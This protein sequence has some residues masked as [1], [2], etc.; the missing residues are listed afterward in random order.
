MIDFDRETVDAYIDENRNLI[1]IDGLI[2]ET[3][4]EKVFNV[5]IVKYGYDPIE[6]R[7]DYSI[8]RDETNNGRCSVSQTKFGRR[9]MTP[10]E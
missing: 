4:I 2:R 10:I 3:E 9:E 6:G 1:K 5:F 7:F 8:R